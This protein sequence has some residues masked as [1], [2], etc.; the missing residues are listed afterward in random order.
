MEYSRGDRG[1]VMKLIAIETAHDKYANGYVERDSEYIEFGIDADGQVA[2]GKGIP[3]TRYRDYEHFAGVI[4]KFDPYAVFL[5]KPV[6]IKKLT[7]EV[8]KVEWK[9][10]GR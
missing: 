9:K 7:L 10:L 5:K 4:G 8:V 1:R 3:T 6:K 2:Y